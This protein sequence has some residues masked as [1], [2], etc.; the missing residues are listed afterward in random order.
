MRERAE[1][2]VDTDRD[3]LRFTGRE[4]EL[5]PDEFRREKYGVDGTKIFICQV[6]P[7]VYT[8]K[9]LGRSYG[10]TDKDKIMEIIAKGLSERF[11]L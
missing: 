3:R 9:I 2:D 1:Y 6:T 4:R 5:N 11:D 7:G 10:A 8:V